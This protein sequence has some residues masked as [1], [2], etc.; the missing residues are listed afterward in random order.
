[1]KS[2]VVFGL[3]AAALAFAGTALAK[4]KDPEPEQTVVVKSRD[5][6]QHILKFGQVGPG[7]GFV[8]QST[9]TANRFQQGEKLKILGREYSWQSGLNAF[10]EI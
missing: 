6:A 9:D 8:A 7:F 5:G 3:A 2:L 10:I 4:G 1:M